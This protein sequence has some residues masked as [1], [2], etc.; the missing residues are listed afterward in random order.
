MVMCVCMTRDLL[1]PQ[2]ASADADVH[3]G[4]AV[5]RRPFWR[6]VQVTVTGVSRVTVPVRELAFSSFVWLHV[7]QQHQLA[8]LAS[9]L[10]CACKEANNM[11][12]AAWRHA[13]SVAVI[14]CDVFSF[15]DSQ[16]E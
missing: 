11:H 4:C 12:Q 10:P 13:V 15:I 2:L 16:W 1:R 5:T 9:V 14:L 7:Q 8:A 6:V 3:E